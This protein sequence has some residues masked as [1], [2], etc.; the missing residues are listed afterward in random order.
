M[1]LP[2]PELW[3]IF[4]DGAKVIT[5]D[6]V[7]PVR[8]HDLGMLT[9]PTGK[10]VVSDPFHNAFNRP[11]DIEVPPDEYVVHMAAVNS[12]E[13]L[14]I[15]LM[16]SFGNG[17]PVAWRPA[18]PPSFTVESAY[19]CLMDARVRHYL[20]RKSQEGKYD[21]YS[22]KFRNAIAETDDLWANCVIDRNSGANVV[23]F[24]A[25]VVESEV[26]VNVGLAANGSPAC[27]SISTFFPWTIFEK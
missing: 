7:I 3:S 27:L 22:G 6:G 24:R 12:G 4:A 11:L 25:N 14:V 16:A 15:V 20:Y 19:G 18:D 26:D 8:V 1:K 5:D 23:L 10:I 9:L 13:T 2:G 17:T 21:R